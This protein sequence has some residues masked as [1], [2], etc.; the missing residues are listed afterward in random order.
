MRWCRWS[1]KWNGAAARGRRGSWPTAVFSRMKIC[2][3]WKD[4]GSKPICPI[5]TGAR[6][7]QRSGG[8]WRGTNGGEQSQFAA[9]ATEATHDRGACLVQETQSAGRAGNRDFERAARDATVPAPGAV[10]GS[11]RMGAR[12]DGLQSSPLSRS[13]PQR[14]IIPIVPPDKANPTP[15]WLCARNHSASQSRHRL[16]RA[17]YSAR[18]NSKRRR[19]DTV[20][21]RHASHII[22]AAP[23]RSRAALLPIFALQ[24]TVGRAYGASHP[25]NRIPRA[26]AS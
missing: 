14:L 17:G 7:E 13:A 1:R 20:S 8:R 23:P 19:C 16:G 2:G 5:R 6:V 22:C 9:D 10:G 15:D 21:R 25:A 11:G 3:R 12:G 26:P 4:A 24:R 18:N